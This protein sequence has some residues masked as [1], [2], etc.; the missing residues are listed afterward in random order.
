MANDNHKSASNEDEFACFY[1]V[2]GK[3]S[4]ALQSPE[5]LTPGTM[6]R[7]QRAIVIVDEEMLFKPIRFIDGISI[8]MYK[9][10]QSGYA[11]LLEGYT[12]PVGRT[13]S[14]CPYPVIGIEEILSDG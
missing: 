3:Y 5:V 1:P 7:P 10:M 4:Y 2:E 11:I 8:V 6:P 12:L 13:E 9:N 14:G